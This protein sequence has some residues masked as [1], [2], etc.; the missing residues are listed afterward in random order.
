[1]KITIT[2]DFH[3]TAASLNIEIGKPLSASQ[4]A[5][6]R[7]TLCGIDG[8]TC[9]GNLGERGAQNVQIDVRGYRND[10]GLDIA[11]TPNE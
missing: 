2:N 3:N 8:C 4:I 1:M 10:G 7:R 11:V 9:G 6:A 5:R